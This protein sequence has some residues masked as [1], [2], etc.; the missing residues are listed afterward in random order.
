MILFLN[1]F[2]LQNSTEVKQTDEYI[3]KQP[4]NTQSILLHL[5]TVIKKTIPEVELLYK[6]GVPY[7][8]FKNKA[9]CYLAYNQK[10]DFVDVGFARGFQLKK[11]QEFLIDENR[12]T[13]KSLRYFKLEGIKNDILIQ[14]LKE[15][16][17][18]Y[19]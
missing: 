9:F 12:N 18:L 19:I 5:I 13:V 1:I 7:F 8:Y 11:N 16:A 14:V 2:I 17:T 10:K 15:A 4:Q 6:Y 3:I